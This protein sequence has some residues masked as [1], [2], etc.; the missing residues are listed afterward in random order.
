MISTSTMIKCPN[1]SLLVTRLTARATDS[2]ALMH[3]SPKLFRKNSFSGFWRFVA[4]S[5]SLSPAI[6]RPMSS[7]STAGRAW[8]WK[9]M[10]WGRLCLVSGQHELARV[11]VHIF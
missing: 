6:T 10:G 11:D 8:L 1:I 3:E 9:V 7:L 2:Y 5:T 4:S